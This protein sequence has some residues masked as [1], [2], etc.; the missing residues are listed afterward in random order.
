MVTGTELGQGCCPYGSFTNT[1]YLGNVI[2]YGAGVALLFSKKN[3]VY[4]ELCHKLLQK[5]GQSVIQ[6]S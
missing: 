6:C 2:G 5:P 1:L 3:C 4:A